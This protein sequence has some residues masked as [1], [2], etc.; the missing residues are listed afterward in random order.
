MWLGA[1]ALRHPAYADL[2]AMAAGIAAAT[3]A[4][5]GTLA[6]GGNAAGAYLAGAVPHRDAGGIKSAATGKSAREMLAAP[7]KA[8]LL[9]GGVEPWADGIGPRC[10]ARAR[11]RV[12]RGRGHAVSPTRR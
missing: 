3:G 5:L 11:R 1:L 2:R 4:T 10:R 6:E 9:F 7:Q 8:Y 12:V